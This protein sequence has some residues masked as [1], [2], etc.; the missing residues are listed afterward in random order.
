MFV[1]RR[2]A[3][4]ATNFFSYYGENFHA[5]HKVLR[6][7]AC[8]TSEVLASSSFVFFVFLVGMKI[9]F[10]NRFLQFMGGITLEFYLIHGLFVELFGYNFAARRR[11]RSYALTLAIKSAK[12]VNVVLNC[13]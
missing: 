4:F 10:G 2:C 12:V 11:G 5:P 9:R 6:R 7:W 8:L 13:V 1:L 3:V